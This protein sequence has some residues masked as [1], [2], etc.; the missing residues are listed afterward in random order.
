MKK[1][2]TTQE[3]N[4]TILLP[5][6]ST[7]RICRFYSS[8]RCEPCLTEDNFTYFEA[9]GGITLEDLPPFPRSDFEDGMPVKMRQVIVGLYMEKMMNKIQELTWTTRY[10][11]LD[12]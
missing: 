2:M 7:C 3:T 8:D 4:K 11:P 10:S 6:F 12:R 9:R 5:V 1:R